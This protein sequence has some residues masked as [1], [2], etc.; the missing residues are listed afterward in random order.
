MV[1]PEDEHGSLIILRSLQIIGENFKSTLQ[2]PNL[3]KAAKYCLLSSLS[4]NTSEVIMRLRD[5]LSHEHSLE[6]RSEIEGKDETFFIHIQNDLKKIG[7]VVMGLLYNCEIRAITAHLR[8]ILLCGN[9]KEAEEILNVMNMPD[10]HGVDFES[11][12]TVEFE[13]VRRI[14]KRFRRK[15]KRIIS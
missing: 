2:S 3:S 1:N 5:S 6:Q 14:D 15:I 4:K 11:I 8:R 13:G 9:F 12:M 7:S 10:S